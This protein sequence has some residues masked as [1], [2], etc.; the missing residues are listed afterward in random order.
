[1][2]QSV[3]EHLLQKLEVLYEVDG[4]YLLDRLEVLCET[5]GVLEVPC[6]TFGQYLVI[7]LLMISSQIVKSSPGGE[8]TVG[9]IKGSMHISSHIEEF[10]P[11]IKHRSSN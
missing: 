7:W 4:E 1:M 10:S 5:V 8:A 11:P 9:S 2:F 6:E 3:G